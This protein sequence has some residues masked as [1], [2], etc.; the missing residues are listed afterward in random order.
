MFRGLSRLLV[1]ARDWRPRDFLVTAI[2]IELVALLAVVSLG[3]GTFAVFTHLATSEGTAY[4][5]LVISAAYGV[6]A[7][8]AGVTLWLRHS[9]S[10]QRRPSAPD[11]PETLE[12]LLRSL[13]AGTNLQ[14]PMALIGALRE[15]RDLSPTELLAVSLIGGFL[16]GRSV[17]K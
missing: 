13:A 2:G 17:G 14:D 16:A 6:A 1:A 5:A 9:R 10:A 4:A 11:L 3:F 8:L 15:G 7:T 12:P